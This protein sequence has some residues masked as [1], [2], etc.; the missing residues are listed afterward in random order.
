MGCPERYAEA[1]Q[2]SS[3]WCAGNLLAGCDTSGKTGQAYLTDDQVN[4]LTKG[5]KANLGMILYNLTTGAQGV[6]TAVEENK[7]TA[8]LSGGAGALGNKWTGGDNYRITLLTGLERAQIEHFLNITAGEISGALAAVGACGCALSDAGAAL[9]KQINI[10][11]AANFYTCSCSG[12]KLEE[13][14]RTQLRFWAKDQLELIR[15]GKIDPCGGVGSE[16]PAF[17]SVELALTEMN[18]ARIVAN[19]AARS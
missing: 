1:W 7:L 9:V 18:A 2:F 11:N 12:P 4:F 16:Y 14:E 13:A 15:T 17:G 10:I 6:V 8:R 5:V 3:F 19:R